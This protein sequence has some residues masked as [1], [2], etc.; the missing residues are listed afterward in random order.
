[1]PVWKQRRPASVGGKYQFSKEFTASLYGAHLEDVWNQYY[2]NL[3][4]VHPLAGDQSVALDF[5]LYRTLDDGSAK[6]GSI[7]TTAARW[8]L[9]TPW[10]RTPSPWP[11]K[12]PW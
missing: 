5:N 8:R 10:A 9:P 3:N 7:D 11:T 4:L 2:V 1:M 6:A 12:D